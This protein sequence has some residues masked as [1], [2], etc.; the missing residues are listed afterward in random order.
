VLL[1]EQILIL[2]LFSQTRRIVSAAHMIQNCSKSR[3]T[4]CARFRSCDG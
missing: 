2:I 4:L 3:S 1:C